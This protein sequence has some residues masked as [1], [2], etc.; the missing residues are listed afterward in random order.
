L[1]RDCLI[2]LPLAGHGLY[3]NLDG[4]PGLRSDPQRTW[5]GVSSH[6]IMHGM[7]RLKVRLQLEPGMHFNDRNLQDF[8]DAF[9]SVGEC[10]HS[11][12]ADDARPTRR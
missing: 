10:N 5:P 6:R 4:V 7:R 2:V 1:N 12:R 3:S 8:P 11:K 9:C